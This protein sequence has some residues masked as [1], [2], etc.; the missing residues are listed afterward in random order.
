MNIDKLSE[1]KTFKFILLIIGELIILL[2]V[3]RLGMMVG[4]EK[5][6]FSYKWGE[7]YH[8]N[9]AGPREGFMADMKGGGFEGRDFMNSHGTFSKI[10]KID[11]SNIIVKGNDNLEKIILVKDDTSIVRLRDNIKLSDLK[12]NDY[13][14]VIGDS[15]SSGQIEAGLIRVMP[16]PNLLNPNVS[17]PNIKNP[18]TK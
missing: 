15:N 8:N 5:A 6:K 14:V 13:I 2:I 3:F 17:P 16:D 4:L 1:S 10:I 9:F 12:V 11:G 7:N 18:N